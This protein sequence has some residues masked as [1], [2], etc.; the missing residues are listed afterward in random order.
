MQI[1]FEGIYL[2]S[3]TSFVNSKS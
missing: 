2:E 3:L 1:L